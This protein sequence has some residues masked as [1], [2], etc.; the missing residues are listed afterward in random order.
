M[1]GKSILVVEENTASRTFPANTLPKR[2]FKVLEASSGKEALI[3]ARRAAPNLILYDPFLLDINDEEFILKFH[4]NVRKS[5]TS[6]LALSSDP[7]PMRKEV[8]MNTGVN[9]FTVKSSQA[10]AL[11]GSVRFP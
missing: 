11:T 8:C 5:A 6:M 1:V 4:N 9:L 3:A 7:G 2:Q 10:T